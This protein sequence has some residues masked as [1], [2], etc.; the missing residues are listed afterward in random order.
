MSQQHINVTIDSER[1]P[2]LPSS[3]SSNANPSSQSQLSSIWGLLSQSTS[4]PQSSQ[5][6]SD[7]HIAH[8]MTPVN[9]SISQT[10][11]PNQNQP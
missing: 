8:S 4:A 3:S 7:R 2:L 9:P 6:Q 5:Q 10:Q 1:A 11:I